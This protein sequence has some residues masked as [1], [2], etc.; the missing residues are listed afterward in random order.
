VGELP[1][2]LDLN[3]EA[4]IGTQDTGEVAIIDGEKR[5]GRGDMLVRPH[6]LRTI[7][8]LDLCAGPDSWVRIRTFVVLKV[9][10]AA[11]D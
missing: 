1:I 7:Y 11:A 9:D 8:Q 4:R 2:F 6:D 3:R 10:I 5:L